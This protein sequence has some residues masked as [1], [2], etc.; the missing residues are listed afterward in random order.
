MLLPLK[1]VQV[2]GQPLAFDLAAE[3][4]AAGASSAVHEDADTTADRT[5]SLVSL[6]TQQ[7]RAQQLQRLGAVL[8]ARLSGG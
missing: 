2:F 8:S 1:A 6:I 7:S 5:A 4:K 3:A